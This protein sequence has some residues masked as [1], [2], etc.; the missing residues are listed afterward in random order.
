M[1]APATATLVP[2][3]SLVH[4]VITISVMLATIMQA[5]DSTIANVALPHMQGSL[6]A[7]QDQMAW[8]LTSYIVAAAITIPLTGWLAGY[9]GRK[10]VFLVS[11]AGFTVASIL[12]GLAE[13]LPQ[14]VIFRL[15]Q[16]ICGAALVPLSQAILFDINSQ[17]NFGRAMAIWGVGVTIGPI[18]GPALGGYLTENYDWR[19]V[20]YINVPIGILAFLGLYLF[21]PE[22][23]VRK[24]KFDFFGFLTL[25]LGVGALQ[26]MLDRGELKDWFSSSEIVIEATLAVLGFYL[27]IIH[28]LTF[29]NPFLNPELFKDRNFMIGNVLIFVIGIVLFAT[30]AL[31]PPMLQ[32]QLNYPVI[33]AGLVTAPRGAGT[34]AAMFLVGRMIGVFDSRAIMAVGLGLTA[35]SLYI[36]TSY[37]LLTDTSAIISAG[38]VQGFGIGLAYVPLSTIAFAE[39]PATLRNEGT[40][41]FNLMRNLGSSIGISIVEA[42]L[43]QNT[44]ILHSVLGEH[45]I[46]YNLHANIAYMANHVNVSTPAGLAALNGIVTNQA[47]MIAYID[48]YKLM[49]IMTLAVIPLLFLLRVPKK[50]KLPETPIAMD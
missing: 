12:C 42:L 31:I 15:L 5:L 25:S 19:W 16:G 28:T 49:M 20:F 34:M 11:I 39:L 36:M 8:V 46:P 21:L 23:P 41:L 7:T 26:M 18:L 6:A 3:H 14:M 1:T 43:T 48:D 10:L 32:N 35:Y 47:I 27:F 9:A 37:S 38:I 2:E 29:K 13:T 45:L 17:H 22:S 4:K 44:Q 24:S 50:T 40:A 33:T 30:L